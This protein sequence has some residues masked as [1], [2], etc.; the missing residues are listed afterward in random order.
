MA[1]HFLQITKAKL[2][3]KSKKCDETQV[4]ISLNKICLM[5]DLFGNKI[6]KM[7]KSKKTLFKALFK[8]MRPL[9]KLL[10]R[11]GV[12]HSEFVEVLKRIYVNVAES[13]PEFR[14]EDRKQSVSRVSV[15]TGLNRKEVSRIQAL[16]SDEEF[17]V[18]THNRAAQVVNGWLRDSAYQNSHGDPIDIPLSDNPISFSSLVKFYSGDMPVRAVLDELIRVGVVKKLDSGMLSLCSKAYI[19]QKSDSEKLGMLGV[20]VTDLLNT[21]EHN[22]PRPHE[23][24]RLQ[25]TLAYDNLPE[26]ALKE[27]KTMSEEHAQ[28][29]LLLLNNWLSKQDRTVNPSV[30]GH[31]RY[32]AGL[33][34]YYFEESINK[35]EK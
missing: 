9:V 23:D 12:S 10:L 22:I 14:L 25:L 6:P 3:P 17:E 35:E 2:K 33:G 16:P 7:D 20:S 15:I 4:F 11:Y 24:S 13:E 34:M 31:G 26:E 30:T 27:F 18:I 32:R 19:P 21:L 1:Y 8:L 28:K 5:L 29:T